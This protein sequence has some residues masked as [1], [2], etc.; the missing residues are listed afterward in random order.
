MT[1][2]NTAAN[3]TAVLTVEAMTG[4][5]TPLPDPEDIMKNSSTKG[6]KAVGDMNL[7]PGLTTC[8]FW[9]PKLEN[10]RHIVSADAVLPDPEKI[11]AAI[12]KL[13]S[14]C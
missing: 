12:T 9:Q 7:L 14:V 4:N 5:A 11:E 3:A 1:A 10:L 6:E 13:V 8:Q 2:S